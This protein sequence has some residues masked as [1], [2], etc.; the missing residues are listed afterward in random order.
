MRFCRKGNKFV[1]LEV[2][3]INLI[4]RW[5][6][7]VNCGVFFLVFINSVKFYEKGDVEIICESKY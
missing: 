4:K 5:K 2:V 1:F 6:V 3:L 7:K